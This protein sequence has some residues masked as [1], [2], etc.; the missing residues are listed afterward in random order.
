MNHQPYDVVTDVGTDVAGLLNLLASSPGAGLDL[1]RLV[2]F[3][4]RSMPVESSCGVTLIR[5]G[6]AP[7]TMVATDEVARTVD[8]LQHRTGEGPSLEAAKV[9]TLRPA[10]DLLTEQRWPVFA[11]RCVAETGIRSILAVRLP[12][13]NGDAAALSFYSRIPRAF[14]DLAAGLAALYAPLATLGVEQTLRA[15]DTEQLGA[16]LTSSRLIG[17]AIGII[18]ERNLVTSEEAMVLLR[19][20]SQHLNRKLRDIAAEVTETGEIPAVPPARA[21]G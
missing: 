13:A 2:S 21:S 18:M 5:K 15:Q 17:T 9:P 14:G 7:R 6:R 8:A 16:A 10:D 12:L 1:P 11:R 4:C 20:S 3:A 19:R